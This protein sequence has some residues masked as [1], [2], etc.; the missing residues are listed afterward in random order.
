MG[1]SSDQW[2]KEN[3][4]SGRFK[5]KYTDKV[6]RQGDYIGQ[7]LLIGSNCEC[8]RCRNIEAEKADVL[9]S[10]GMARRYKYDNSNNNLFVG[11][12]ISR[13]SV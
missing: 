11:S 4:D 7:A 12:I 1:K 6:K 2:I 5:E 3:I 10:G 9:I 8:L 13:R